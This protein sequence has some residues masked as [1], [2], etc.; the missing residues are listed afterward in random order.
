MSAQSNPRKIIRN[1][2][3]LDLRTASEE[4]VERIQRIDNV[5]AILYSPATA[6]LA[7]RIEIG[8]VAGMY[9]AAPEA[10]IIS[11]QSIFGHDAFVE[12][13]KPL[14]GI[15]AGQVFF[16]PDVTVDDIRIGIGSLV[17]TGQMLYPSH[18][19]GVL[20]S[21]VTHSSGQAFAYTQGA[22]LVMG[23]LDLT[24]SYVAALEDNSALL[25]MGLLAARTVI[26]NDLLGRK[27]REVQVMGLMICREE[28]SNVLLGR[29][30]ETFNPGHIIV[31]PA[32]F[33]P[34]DGSLILDGALLQALPARKLYCDHVR[35]EGDVTPEMLD[36]AVDALRIPGRLIAPA[37]L[38]AVLARKCNLL[39]TRAVFY[40]GALWHVDGE[41]TLRP[42]RFDYLDGKATL[43]VEGTLTVAAQVDPAVLA[44][45]LEKVHNFGE[46]VC[47]PAQIAALQARLGNGEGQFVDSTAEPETNENII[48]NAAYLK[49]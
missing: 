3:C 23:K 20:Q 18:L 12:R 16:L 17:V 13:D 5:A 25:V 46:I 39:E 30:H 35:I 49:L 19:A 6:G 2:A 31:V 21:K 11:G 8:N 47:T 32:G 45:R 42:E 33:E 36:A 24:E 9:E 27:V 14:E 37:A 38:R 40:T 22:K 10:E 34:V 1:V 44:Q 7:S 29:L 4:S 43:I 28:N 48:A 41:E 15:I 26:P